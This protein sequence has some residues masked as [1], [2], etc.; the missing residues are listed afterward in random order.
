M[1]I[2]R[3][4]ATELME[5]YGIDALLASTSEN[6]MYCSDYDNCWLWAYRRN[7]TPLV[8][9]VY[10]L[11]PRDQQLPPALVIPTFSAAELAVH[12]TWIADVQTYGS[13]Y[14]ALLSPDA[15]GQ[16][17]KRAYAIGGDEARNNKD[18][19]AALVKTIKNR[20]LE[21][22]TIGVELESGAPLVLEGLKTE[23]PHCSFGNA[24]EVFRLLRMVKTPGEIDR[25]RQAAIVNQEAMFAVLKETRDGVSD[26]ELTQVFRE[27]LAERGADFE[28]FNCPTEPGGF[29]PPYGYRLRKGDLLWWDGGCVLNRYHADTGMTA[30][31]G[32]EPS[33][34][35][36]KLYRA[37]H[38]SLDELMDRA[39]PGV[40][41]SELLELK[42]KIER[43]EGIG[44]PM[45][46]GGHGIGIASR[47][48]PLL[49]PPIP[50]RD[51]FFSG[52]SDLPLENGT[53][54]CLETPYFDPKV[55]NVHREHTVVITEHGC[56]LITPEERRLFYS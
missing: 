52:S 40:R 55:G 35:Q 21:K 6:V 22:G 41:P 18:P 39:R 38:K 2:N 27:K 26:L 32:G 4:R 47:D 8:E 43:A 3:N 24:S 28:W 14:G 54:L 33:A 5:R 11:I 7:N 34:E 19:I 16:A 17:A 15:P 46:F 29:F 36:V 48:L 51:D 45:P 13:P 37:I 56:E 53:V 49:L 31:V 42:M 50:I 23:L 20:K 44:T 10:A 1:L 30:I 9:Q 12:P 25:I